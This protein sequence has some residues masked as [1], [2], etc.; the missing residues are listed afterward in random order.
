VIARAPGKVLVS[1]AYAVLDGAPAIVAAVDRYVVADGAKDAELV[2]DEVRAAIEAG[3]ILRAPSFDASALRTGDSGGGTRKLGLGSSAAILVASLGAAWPEAM[4]DDALRREVFPVALAAHRRAQGGGSGVDVA[5]SVYG[6]VLVARPAESGALTVTPHALPGDPTLTILAFPRSAST[7]DLVG[8]V[9][10]LRDRDP[11]A[12]ARAMDR[13]RAG[14][15]DAARATTLRGL[16]EA[17]EVQLDALEALGRA[18]GAPIVLPELRAFADAASHEGAV[19]STAG[20]GGGDLALLVGPA[21]P[22]PRLLDRARE[23]GLSPLRIAVDA[24]GLTL[25]A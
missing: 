5:A 16:L 6:G 17:L 12:Y 18:A 24:P 3:A 8:C 7:R 13:A 20:A 4:E 2:T 21:A 10:A 9:R 25:H 1:G 23:L 22:S 11:T 14:A 19:A 15:E